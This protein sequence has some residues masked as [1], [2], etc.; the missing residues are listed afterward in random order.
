MDKESM[1]E[2]VAR[3]LSATKAWGEFDMQSPAWQQA[4]RDMARLVIQV[5]RE[6]TDAMME[7]PPDIAGENPGL[8]EIWRAMIDAALEKSDA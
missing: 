6:P 7:A 5:M 8:S 3:A 2:R 1:I 4:H